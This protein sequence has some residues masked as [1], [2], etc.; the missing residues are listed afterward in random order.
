MRTKHPEI[1][2]C[3]FRDLSQDKI[4]ADRMLPTAMMLQKTASYLLKKIQQHCHCN[5]ICIRRF[6]L[7]LYSEDFEI[8]SAPTGSMC[9]PQPGTIFIAIKLQLSIINLL[10]FLNNSGWR[11]TSL[12]HGYYILTPYTK[13]EQ[14]ASV[15]ICKLLIHCFAIRLG[16]N[17]INGC[18][19]HT[20]M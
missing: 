18:R 11:M 15:I 20:Y 8:V 1:D 9:T 4:D 12:Q 17:D 16:R 19:K 14:A 10:N 6:S 13:M 5:Q 7:A 3:V 2:F